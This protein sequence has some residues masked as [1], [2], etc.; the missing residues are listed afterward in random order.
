[1]LTTQGGDSFGSRPAVTEDT[2]PVITVTQLHKIDGVRAELAAKG[3]KI[4]A[5]SEGMPRHI[6]YEPAEKP[7]KKTAAK[8]PASK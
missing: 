3:M 7:A 2:M 5:E 8:S 6:S 4:V 1:M